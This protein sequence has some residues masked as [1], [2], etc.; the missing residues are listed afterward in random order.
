MIDFHVLSLH[1]SWFTPLLGY[2]AHHDQFV[3]FCIDRA[4]PEAEY[5]SRH[6]IDIFQ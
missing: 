5:F 6:R 3:K 2:A 4:R 1:R